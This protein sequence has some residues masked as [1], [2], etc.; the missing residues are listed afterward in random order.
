MYFNWI[1]MHTFV[2]ETKMIT[3]LHC[4]QKLWAKEDDGHWKMAG[5]D[6]TISVIRLFLCMISGTELKMNKQTNK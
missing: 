3:E 5:L 6:L 2:H 4:V 1:D